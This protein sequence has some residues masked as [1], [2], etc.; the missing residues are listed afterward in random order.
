MGKKVILT[1][2]AIILL[3][4]PIKCD[5]PIYSINSFEFTAILYMIRFN[6]VYCF[7]LST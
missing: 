2:V 3:L 6:H 1:V 4:Q 5:R 7:T